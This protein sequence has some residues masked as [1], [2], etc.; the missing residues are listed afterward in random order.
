MNFRANNQS[1]LGIFSFPYSVWELILEG[2]AFNNIRITGR[3]FVIAF[4]VGDWERDIDHN[5]FKAITVFAVV[6]TA[7]T[8]AVVVVSLQRTNQVGCTPKKIIKNAKIS[9]GTFSFHNT[10]G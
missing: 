1:K 3:A 7:A 4:P 5:Y 8:I 10:L 2:S 6:G 9:A